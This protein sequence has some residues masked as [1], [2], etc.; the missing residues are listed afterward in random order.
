[1]EVVVGLVV[2]GVVGELV[3][4]VVCTSVDVAVA[5]DDPNV[6][7]ATQA[8]LKFLQKPAN[9]LATAMCQINV[10]PAKESGVRTAV[11]GRGPAGRGPVAARLGVLV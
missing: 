5:S 3:L 6:E 2:V 8:L 4:P 11:D 1:M 10:V 9:V 7:L